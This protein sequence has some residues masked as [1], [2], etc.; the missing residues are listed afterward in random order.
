MAE[1]FDFRTVQLHLTDTCNLRCSYC[2]EA[3]APRSSQVISLAAAQAIAARHLTE[4]GSHKTVEF[5]FIGGEPLL[6]WDRI[7]GVVDFVHQRH[8]P[9]EHSFSFSTNGTLF[10]DEIK[11]WLD[12]HNC[13]SFSFSIDGT[14]EAHNKNRCGSYDRAIQHVPWALERA[15]R[16]KI[17]PRVKMTIGPDT[18]PMMAE[19]ILEL[20]AMGFDKVDANVPY[21]NIWG[22][23]LESSLIS[24][25]GQ[26]DQLVDYYLLHP[27]L[28]PSRLIDLP[29]SKL[30]GT[31]GEDEFPRW[32]GSGSPM[33]C[34]DV[35]GRP[36]P[37]HRFV[38]IS[39]GRIYEGPL[40]FPIKTW[41]EVKKSKPSPCVEC[42]FVAA[43]PSCMA[44]NWLENGDVDR[45]THWHCGFI[46][47]QIKASAKFKILRL[48][49]DIA[50]APQ[51]DE[52]RAKVS[53]YQAELDRALQVHEL[54]SEQAV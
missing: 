38:S 14:R 44:L 46:L 5:D 3:W 8:W 54:L 39:T 21:E 48:S 31:E 4:E 17:Q 23:R 34:Y 10:N 1:R 42:P 16:L 12:R 40:T 15:A 36:L 35:E 47:L 52:G 18:V 30:V 37:C 43:C 28:E 22:D 9:K 13:I 6:A 19:G 24:F 7:V 25:A 32:C 29:F 33:I 27:D 51:T 20:H 53:E 2:Y 45:R 41:E 11:A 50:A 49:R 26:L